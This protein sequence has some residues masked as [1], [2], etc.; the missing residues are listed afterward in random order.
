MENC[1]ICHDD[2]I[3][4]ATLIVNCDKNKCFYNIHS[5]CLIKWNQVSNN[6]CLICKKRNKNNHN[7]NTQIDYTY[8]VKFDIN[9]HHIDLFLYTLINVFYFNFI[10]RIMDMMMHYMFS[11]KKDYM[12]PILLTLYMSMNIIIITLLFFPAIIITSLTSILINT[13]KLFYDT[14]VIIK[15]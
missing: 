3:N 4:N 15:L 2:N 7:V 11:V 14:I 13:Y 12:K 10:I 8:D 9:M 1:I 6:K 5:D